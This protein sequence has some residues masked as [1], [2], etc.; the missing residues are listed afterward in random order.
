MDL[1]SIKIEALIRCKTP[2][3]LGIDTENSRKEDVVE[4]FSI[5]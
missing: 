5:E 4:V 3:F 2:V 1:E